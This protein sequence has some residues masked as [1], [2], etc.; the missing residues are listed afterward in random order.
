[1]HDV[2]VGKMGNLILLPTSDII[3]E[4]TLSTFGMESMLAAELRTDIY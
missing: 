3:P 4:T 1:M 2:I